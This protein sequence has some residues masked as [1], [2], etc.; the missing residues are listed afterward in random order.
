MGFLD[1]LRAF[2]VDG[3]SF[4]PFKFESKYMGFPFLY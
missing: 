4:T 2:V 3:S 1:L